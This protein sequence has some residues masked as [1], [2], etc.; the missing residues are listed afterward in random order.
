M[1]RRCAESGGVRKGREAYGAGQLPVGRGGGNGG[2]HGEGGRNP[3]ASA[4][5]P[6]E[7]VADRPAGHRSS[8][9]L[10]PPSRRAAPS[11]GSL[12]KSTFQTRPQTRSGPRKWIGR[13]TRAEIWRWKPEIRHD[14]RVLLKK[15][16]PLVVN[17]IGAVQMSSSSIRRPHANNDQVD[18][19]KRVTTR[20]LFLSER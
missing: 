11:G 12:R 4:A 17:L 15:H 3:A 9:A 14:T 10:R 1:R 13:L 18:G 7:E 2:R 19:N 6:E 5:V 8:A 16:I 20:F